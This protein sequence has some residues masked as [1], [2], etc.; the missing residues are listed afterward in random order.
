MKGKIIMANIREFDYDS[1]DEFY[2]IA[3]YTPGGAPYGIT[4]EQAA[5]DGLLDSE[6]TI[7][8]DQDFPF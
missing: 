1:D 5:E 2:Y 8:P 7:E 3:G 4:W 6:E